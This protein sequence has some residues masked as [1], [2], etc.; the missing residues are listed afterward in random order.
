MSTAEKH[1]SLSIFNGQ[2]AGIFLLMK[3]FDGVQFDRELIDPPLPIPNGETAAGDLAAAKVAKRT[4]LIVTALS[5]ASSFSERRGK[6]GSGASWRCHC[7]TRLRRGGAA[8]RDQVSGTMA[9]RGHGA[10][11]SGH[12]QHQR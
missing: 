7:L 12:V 4:S 1:N 5:T 8:R 6:I 3:M 10:S 9:T 11:A 2:M